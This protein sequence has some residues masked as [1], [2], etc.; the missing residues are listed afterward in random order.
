MNDTPPDL[1]LLDLSDLQD[2]PTL[3]ELMESAA[4]VQ[5]EAVRLPAPYDVALLGASVEAHGPDRFCYSLKRLT[6]FIMAEYEVEP[7]EA[8]HIL[9]TNFMMPLA[10]EH[11][12]LAPMWIND[13]ILLGS[14]EDDTKIQIVTP[15]EF[16]KK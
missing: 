7:N 11:G 2:E 6:K 4:E 5:T 16:G 15:I 10:R 13:E 1:T 3:S 8:R 9:A 12:P 14:V